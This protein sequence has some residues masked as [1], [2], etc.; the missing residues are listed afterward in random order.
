M[1][2]ISDNVEDLESQLDATN[3]EL[4][5]AEG[6]IAEL[7]DELEEVKQERDDLIEQINE[8]KAQYEPDEVEF[9]KGE[10]NTFNPQIFN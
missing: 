6:K 1:G 2:K 8:L 7:E 4:K 5:C 10:Q 3:D 9:Q